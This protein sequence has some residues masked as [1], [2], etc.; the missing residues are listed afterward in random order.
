[1]IGATLR[2]ERSGG[3]EMAIGVALSG[4][5]FNSIFDS[6]NGGPALKE[7]GP[8]LETVFPAAFRWA[9]LAGSNFRSKRYSGRPRDIRL[10]REYFFV[11]R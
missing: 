7:Y 4:L 2:T 5:I 1:M 9:M 8:D 10:I 3:C 11:K 6:Q